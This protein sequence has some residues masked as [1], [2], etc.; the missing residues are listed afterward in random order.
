[1]TREDVK[2]MLMVITN[3][4]P[5]FKPIDLSA[6]VD[7]WF[8]ILQDY[9]VQSAMVALKTYIMTDTKGFA[10]TVG[11]II[12]KMNVVSEMSELT[13]MEAWALVGRALRDSTYHAQER[14]NELPPTVQKAVGSADNLRA[15]GLDENYNENV[16]QSQFIK[17]YERVLEHKKEIARMPK[18]VRALLEQQTAKMIEG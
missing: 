7:I 3:A 8:D 15:W 9:P 13:A 14:F 4:Y 5:S 12:E 16:A 17:A 18:E 1:M 11:Q 2:K 6:T 10:P